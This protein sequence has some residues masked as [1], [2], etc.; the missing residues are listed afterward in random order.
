MQK[1]KGGRFSLAA[2]TISHA[3]DK[4]QLTGVTPT[5][6]TSPSKPVNARFKAA[7]ASEAAEVAERMK[8]AIS[9]GSAAPSPPETS[10]LPKTPTAKAEE[11][12]E[13]LQ[14]Q[15]SANKVEAA[16]DA[17]RDRQLAES[18]ANADVEAAER[19]ANQ[20][21]ADLQMEAERERRVSEGPESPSSQKALELQR[22]TSMKQADLQMEAERARRVS[23]GPVATPTSPKPTP[24]EP[25]PRRGSATKAVPPPKP[26]P[27]PPPAAMGSG[28]G[29]LPL[30][31]AVVPQLAAIAA[32]LAKLVGI[33]FPWSSSFLKDVSSHD[34]LA[35]RLDALVSFIEQCAEGVA[36]KRLEGITVRLE[37]RVGLP[38]A[39]ASAPSNG[40][41][42]AVESKL[43]ELAGLVARMEAAVGA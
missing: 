42:V 24:P 29:L 30:T 17:E 34:E 13:K 7:S 27:L 8:A 39:A 33:P 10:K 37:R 2:A 26:A 28:A 18:K 11:P 5:E 6:G 15:Q 12:A 16:R 38:S 35:K 1:L 14:R 22:R 3:E 25:P 4:L 9:G 36:L 19:K 21:K 31:S 41:A 40:A 20:A 43:T 32:R 23:E